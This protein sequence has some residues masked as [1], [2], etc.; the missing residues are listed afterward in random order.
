MPDLSP[1]EAEQRNQVEQPNQAPA[2]EQQP[3]QV[4]NQPLHAAVEDPIQPVDTPTEEP[5][6]PNQPNQ[7]PILQ[8]PMANQQL[9]WSYF[10]PQFAGKTDEDVE[11]LLLRTNDWMDT[12]NFPND[13]K[14]RRFC[15]TL[16]G[17]ARLWYETVKNANLDWPAMQEHFRQQYSKFGSTREQYFHIW[18]SFQFD[19]ARHYRWVHTQS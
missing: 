12:H 17:K 18:R 8:D 19:E 3:N 16:T 7:P 4:P 2:E 11:V 5:N 9:N 14:V 15:L 6:Q 1:V 10:K 13:Q